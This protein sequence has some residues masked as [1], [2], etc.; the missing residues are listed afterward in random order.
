MP[1]MKPHEVAGQ[2]YL[3][4]TGKFV[5]HV[6][7]KEKLTFMEARRPENIPKGRWRNHFKFVGI[8]PDFRGF[9]KIKQTRIVADKHFKEKRLF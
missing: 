1:D 2:K 5:D 6:E 8:L 3:L 7:K 4:Q 9:E